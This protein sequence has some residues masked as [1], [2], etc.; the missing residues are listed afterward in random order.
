MLNDSLQKYLAYRRIHVTNR[1]MTGGN[2]VVGLWRDRELASERVE[3][4][5]EAL[6]ENEPQYAAADWDEGTPSP[7]L[8][9]RRF[10]LSGA[11]LLATL[12]LGSLGYERFTALAGRFPTLGDGLDFIALASAPLALI[13][14]VWLIAV[15]SGKA[16]QRRFQRTSD[17]IQVE[18]QRLEA[19][20]SHVTSR[21]D[22]SR[23]ALA[24]QGDMLLG[25]GDHAASRLSGISRA[26]EGEIQTVSRHT[27]ALTGSAAAARGDLAVLL[28]NLP[29]ADVQTRQMVASLREAGLVA[30]EQA[31]ALDTHA[32][33]ADARAKDPGRGS[34][35]PDS[36][37]SSAHARLL[38]QPQ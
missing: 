6:I 38:R 23:T 28:A 32:E 10:A 26:M 22:A 17:A 18:V 5:N 34:P 36:R 2:S 31:G 19:L 1:V 20:L 13:A 12:W 4:P 37:P 25:M 35:L 21:L 14:V 8:W 33:R 15:R 3:D 29:K 24:E 16:E 7:G 27:Q 9:R 30:H 11:L